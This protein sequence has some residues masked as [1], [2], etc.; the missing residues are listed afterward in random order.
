MPSSAV[1]I[2]DRPTTAV[3]AWFKTGKR[4]SV[5]GHGFTCCDPLCRNGRG[6][7]RKR[8]KRFLHLA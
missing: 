7:T 4:A 3:K 5:V 2:R 1:R 6:H 8:G